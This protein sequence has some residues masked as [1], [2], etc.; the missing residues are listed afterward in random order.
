MKIITEKYEC[1]CL[2]YCEP[3]SPCTLRD[4][5]EKCCQDGDICKICKKVICAWIYDDEGYCQLCYSQRDYKNNFRK[6]WYERESWIPEIHKMLMG[7]YKES[8]SFKEQSK[9]WIIIYRSIINATRSQTVLHNYIASF[10]E[11]YVI[12]NKIFTNSTVKQ[13]VKYLLQILYAIICLVT[14]NMSWLLTCL[15]VCPPKRCD[16]TQSHTP[17]SHCN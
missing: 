9:H 3:Q 15:F 13:H 5:S 6:N 8:R 2:D 7:L 16:L 1:T 12:Y 4:E 17:G 11:L 10:M 14:L